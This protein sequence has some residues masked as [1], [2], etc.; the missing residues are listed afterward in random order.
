VRRRVVGQRADDEPEGD[1]VIN[2]V[3]IRFPVSELD[4]G[5][6]IIRIARLPVFERQPRIQVRACNDLRH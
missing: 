3:K 5:M 6:A 4:L 1:L 2:Q